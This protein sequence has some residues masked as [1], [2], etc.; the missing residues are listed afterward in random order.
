MLWKLRITTNA[1]NRNSCSFCSMIYIQEKPIQSTGT[2]K[3]KKKKIQQRHKKE[4]RSMQVAWC[5]LCV[6]F[7]NT[8]RSV[9]C[10]TPQ[11]FA[12]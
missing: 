2:T 10:I 9:F 1:S 11:Q 3:K 8:P 5:P 7:K 4:S 6:T 12:V